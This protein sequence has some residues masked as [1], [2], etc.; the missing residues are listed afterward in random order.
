MKIYYIIDLMIFIMLHNIMG[1]LSVAHPQMV[2]L[3]TAHSIF[4]FCAQ[5]T[6]ILYFGKIGLIALKDRD[7]RKIQPKDWAP[8]KYHRKVEMWTESSTLLDLSVSSVNLD[9]NTPR[10]FS[11][12][13]PHK[14]QA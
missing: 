11:Y 13:S 7:F 9:I 1:N 5:H 10:P 12:N 4:W 6:V 8:V 2:I 3:C 14:K